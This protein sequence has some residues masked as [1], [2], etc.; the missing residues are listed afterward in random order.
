MNQVKFSVFADIHHYPGVF[1]TDARKRLADIFKRAELNKV[2]FILSLGD[3]NHSIGSFPDIMEDA[4]KAPVPFY[5]VMGNHD[6]DGASLQEVLKAYK[7]P[8]EYYWIDINGFRF[9]M[10]DTNYYAHAGGCTHYQYRNYF[11]FPQ[12][13]ETLP[14]EELDFLKKAIE[15]SPYQCILCS[16]ASLERHH[17]GGGGLSNMNELRDVIRRANAEE[18]KVIM[19]LNGHHH[20]DFLCIKD[21]VAYFDVNSASFDWLSKPHELFPAE[22]C[23]EYELAAHQAIYS[24]ALS[25]IVTVSE[26]GTIKIEGCRTGFLHGITREMSPNPVCDGAGRPCTAEILSAHFK[27]L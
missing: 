13:R 25:A 6:T 7:M 10:L 26:D 4:E 12:T 21:N 8:H 2:D 20:R 9:I 17:N 3:F 22:L 16:H 18:R 23:A 19:S 1:C 11:D 24:D 14:Q 27:L 15:T 5:H